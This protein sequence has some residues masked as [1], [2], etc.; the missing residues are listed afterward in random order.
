MRTNKR[1]SNRTVVN[2]ENRVHLNCPIC[3]PNQGENASG[4]RRP[5]S[6]KYKSSRKGKA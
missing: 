4:K 1:E 6:D 2:R 5:R 3:P